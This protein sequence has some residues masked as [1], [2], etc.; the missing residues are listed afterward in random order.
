MDR[1]GLSCCPGGRKDS[2]RQNR[3]VISGLQSAP[4]TSAKERPQAEKKP[5]K[6]KKIFHGRDPSSMDA[7]PRSNQCLILASEF[8]RPP[9]HGLRR[10]IFPPRNYFTALRVVRPGSIINVEGSWG[11]RQNF[12][13]RKLRR[14]IGGLSS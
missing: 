7:S 11:R 6:F 13:G 3:R 12:R 4:L 2:R 14:Q 8:F 5:G 9:G 1:E 10:Q